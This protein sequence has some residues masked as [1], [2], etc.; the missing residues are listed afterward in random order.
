MYKYVAAALIVGLAVGPASARDTGLSAGVG[1]NIGG[2]AVGAGVSAG[3]Q[4]VSAGIGVDTGGVGGPSVGGSVSTGK[5]SLGVS[6]NL[7]STGISAGTGALSSA[8]ATRSSTPDNSAGFSSLQGT[9]LPSSLRP[10][11]LKRGDTRR[12]ASGYPFGPLESLNTIPGTPPKVVNACRAAI[13]SAAKALGAVRVFAVSAGALKQHQGVLAA[14]IKVRIDYA[15]KGIVQIRQA[16]V[17]CTLDASGTV[18]AV[19]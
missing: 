17:S 6:G 3:P 9:D 13:L 7:G 2:V 1:A 4:G 16:K 19:I 18:T 10:S 12:V 8:P 14:P 11:I 5:T 15:N